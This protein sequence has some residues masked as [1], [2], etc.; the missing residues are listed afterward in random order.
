MLI[1]MQVQPISIALTNTASTKTIIN[2]IGKE[3]TNKIFGNLS[4]C[5][6]FNLA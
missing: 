5:I 6:F 1:L 3:N 4:I 2:K